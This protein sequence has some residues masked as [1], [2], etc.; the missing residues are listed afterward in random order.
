MA[1]FLE[2][3]ERMRQHL[4]S[5]NPSEDLTIE[6][7]PRWP[8]FVYLG[9]AISMLLFSAFYHNN[10]CK[11]EKTFD[12]LLKLDYVGI[13]VMIAGGSLPVFYYG[14]MCNL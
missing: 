2:L 3:T 11:N 12:F 13:G 6:H 7:V 8:L 9:C 4:Q 10:Y 5:P 14:Y 1:K